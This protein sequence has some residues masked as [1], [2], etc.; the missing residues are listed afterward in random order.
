MLQIL[1]LNDKDTDFSGDDKKSKDA[2][3]D[4]VEK[5]NPIS[6]LN[7][8]NNKYWCTALLQ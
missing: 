7:T 5:G 8:V 2:G 6:L 4:P 3:I 1:F